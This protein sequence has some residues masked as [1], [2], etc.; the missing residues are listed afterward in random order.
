MKYTFILAL[1]IS[2]LSS[3]SMFPNQEVK[4]LSAKVDSLARIIDTLTQQNK[5][6]DEEF[7]W[8]ENELVNLSTAQPQK[9]KTVT[10][11]AAPATQTET[12]VA[13]P[14]NDWQCQALTSSG[15]RCSRPTI[16][17]SKYCWQHKKTYEPN[18]PLPESKPKPAESSNADKK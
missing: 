17:G 7:T 2:V 18:N 3:C 9:S 15:K 16:E 11:I 8:I 12:V 10:T 4:V 5:T 13:K 6:L 1:V 14:A